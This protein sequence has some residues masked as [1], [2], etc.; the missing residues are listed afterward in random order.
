MHRNLV[1][2]AQD[3]SIKIC[4]FDKGNGVAIFSAKDYYD[5]LDK[6]ILDKSKF[7]EINQELS[8]NHPIIQ[9]E[10]SISYYIRK[11]FKKVT[12]YQE[13]IS[14]GSQPGKLYGIAK[15]HKTNVPLRPVVSMVGT[16]EYKLAKYLDNLIKPHIPDTYLLHSTEN[17]I[18]RLKEC[19]CNNK[20]TMVSFDVVS[21]FTNVPLAE[22]IEL[23]IER[24][25]DNNNS[26]AIPFEKSVFRQLMF[27]ATQGLFMY[28]DKLYKQIDGVTMGSPLGPTLANFF[29]GCLEEKIFKHNCNVVPK[30]YLLYIDDSYALFDDKKDCFKFLDILNSQHNDIKFTIEQSTKAN[31]LSFLDVQVKLFNDGYETNVWRKFTNTGLLLNFNAM[32]PKIWKSGLI[33]CFLHRAE[34]ICSNYKLY[35]KE[36]QKLRL[37]FNNNGYSNWFI[38]NT[39][40]KFEEQ[41]AAKNNSQKTEKDFF[42]TLGLPYFGNSSR[43]FAKKLSVLIKRKFDVDINVYYTTFKTG[44][45]FQLKCSTPLSLMSNVVYKFNCS[46]DADLSYIGMTT[47]HLS[48]RVR[49]HL[50]SK[51]RLAVGKHIDNCHVCKQKPV[52]VKHFKIMRACSTEY[53]TKIQ[54]ALL[55]KKCNPKLNSQW[56]ANGSSFLL[57]VF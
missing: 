38:D 53:N 26:N 14:S 2:L 19:P 31:T 46:C 40:K 30:L 49:E 51:V 52:G 25:Y 39:L 8:E 37:I 32:C 13:L 21:L 35:L 9:K 36:V 41:S 34:S 57:N 4:K 3:P 20:N 55:I 27:M 43:Q 54:E 16:P 6:V 1:G 33:M 42:F 56:Y 29:L 11:Y 24:L 44:F 12:N 28:N 10:K 17:F 18:E 15:V 45:Y 5:K 22:T 7:E 50:H 23:V 47:R 48:V